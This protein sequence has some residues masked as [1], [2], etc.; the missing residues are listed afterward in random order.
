M[1]PLSI[2]FVQRCPTLIG[3][4]RQSTEEL[5]WLSTSGYEFKLL[6]ESGEIMRTHENATHETVFNELTIFKTEFEKNEQVLVSS[7]C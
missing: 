2:Y 4:M 1:Q 6:L 5:G 7:S 3:I